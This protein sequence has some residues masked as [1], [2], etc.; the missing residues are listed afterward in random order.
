MPSRLGILDAQGAALGGGFGAQGV[1]M[2]RGVVF[3]EEVGH[4]TAGHCCW[5]MRK[6]C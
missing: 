1:A 3:Q 5:G 4:E 2:L 6:C